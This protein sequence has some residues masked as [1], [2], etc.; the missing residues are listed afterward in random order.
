ME[1]KKTSDQFVDHSL[2]K[3]KKLSS[4]YLSHGR[5]QDNWEITSLSSKDLQ[6]HATVRMTSYYVSSTDRCGFHLTSYSALEFVSQLF[7]IFSHIYA[8][9]EEK[10]QE[11]WMLESSVICRKAI[12]D[13]ENIQVDMEF[14]DMRRFGK[15]GRGIAKARVYDDAGE[16]EITIKALLA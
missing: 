7:V 8:G 16:F 4:E 6:L 13:P 9:F 10:T 1:D 15:R 11:G 2:E 3:I 12:R 5:K 14:D